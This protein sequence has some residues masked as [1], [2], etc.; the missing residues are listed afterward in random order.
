MAFTQV[1]K[2]QTVT[3]QVVSSSD[4]L[5]VNSGGTAINT[6]VDGG[7]LQVYAGGTATGVVVQTGPLEITNGTAPSG[8]VIQ[9]PGFLMLYSGATASNVKIVSG[10]AQIYP[11]ATISGLE[12]AGIYATADLAG[13]AYIPDATVTL[14]RTTDILTISGGAQPKQCS[15]QAITPSGRSGRGR[16]PAF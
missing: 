4:F 6:T 9:A 1:S 12:L 15:L 14:D 16:T 7:F 10:T 13:L 8:T 5:Q 11:G 2:N 3:G